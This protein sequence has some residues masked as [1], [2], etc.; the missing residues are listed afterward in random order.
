MYYYLYA[1]RCENEQYFAGCTARD[2]MRYLRNHYDIDRRDLYK[3]VRIP[4]PPTYP[5]GAKHFR[6]IHKTRI[7]GHRRKTVRVASILIIRS[8]MPMHRVYR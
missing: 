6:I 7:A 2:A 5:T 3:I 8:D 1:G 4:T